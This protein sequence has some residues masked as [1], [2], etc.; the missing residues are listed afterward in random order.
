MERG[1]QR[2]YCSQGIPRERRVCY[3]GKQKGISP[4]VDEKYGKMTVIVNKVQTVAAWFRI[5]LLICDLNG[6]C[7]MLSKYK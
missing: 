7:I 2:L 1:I 4:K 5:K 6:C 3:E